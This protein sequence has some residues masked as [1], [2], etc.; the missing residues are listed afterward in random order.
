MKYKLSDVFCYLIIFLVGVFYISTLCPGH[1]WG[2]DFSA[3]INGAK[4]IV[5]GKSYTLT[6]FIVNPSRQIGPG[7]YPPLTS[8]CLAPLYAVFGM[9]ISVFQLT[10]IFFFLLFLIIFWRFI[11]GGFSDVYAIV[12]LIFVAM[13]PVFWSFKNNVLSEYYFMFFL[14]LAILGIERHKD[15]YASQ[16]SWG[17]GATIGFLLFGL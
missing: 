10:G 8:L 11:R 4:N 16:N 2:D 12:L 17:W 3:Y 5:E 1:N 9:N 14:Y 15:R 13:N 6:G 7:S